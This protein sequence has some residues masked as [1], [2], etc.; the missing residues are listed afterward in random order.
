MKNKKSKAVNN[1]TALLFLT[2]G[3]KVN[4]G[5]AFLACAAVNFGIK[6]TDAKSRAQIE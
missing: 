5:F 4:I 1:T 3:I 6:P 2:F